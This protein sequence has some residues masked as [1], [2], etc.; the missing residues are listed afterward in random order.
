MSVIDSYAK[1]IAAIIDWFTVNTNPAVEN[2]TQG[3][4]AIYYGPIS[5]WVITNDVKKYELGF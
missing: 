1:L 3:A 4:Y 5:E 2:T